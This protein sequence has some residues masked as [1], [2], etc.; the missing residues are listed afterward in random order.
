MKPL[1]TNTLWGRLQPLLPPPP[2]RRFRFPGRKSLDYRKVLTGILFVLKAGIAWDDL[3]AELGCGCG[4]TCRRY[5]RA[6]RQAGVWERLHGVLLAE[7]N[8]AAQIDWARVLIDAPLAQ[9]PERGESTG[10]NP[11][12]RSKSGS[13]H[14]VTP[15][16]RQGDA[17]SGSG[18][19]GQNP[20]QRTAMM[21]GIEPQSSPSLGTFPPGA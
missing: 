8:D 3:P 21:V 19:G 5:L 20:G 15:P 6:W 14:H 7:L 11:T 1:V 17:L 2:R 13:K 10:P 9:A 12:A 4:K 16:T 18:D